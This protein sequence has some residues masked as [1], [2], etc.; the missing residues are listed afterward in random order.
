MAGEERIYTK[1]ENEILIALARVETMQCVLNE[2]FGSHKKDDNSN[3]KNLYDADKQINASINGI[4]EKLAKRDEALKTEIFKQTRS[5][6][7]TQTDFKV[8]KTWIVTGVIAGT[9]VGT[10]VASAIMYILRVSGV[11]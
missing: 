6:F 10:I 7:A 8:F 11:H 9:T 4:P 3:F 5:E 2:D 1:G